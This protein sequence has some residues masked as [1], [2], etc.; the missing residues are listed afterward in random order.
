MVP[1]VVGLSMGEARKQM[2]DL[3]LRVLDDA[4]GQTVTSQMPSAGAKLRKGGQVMLY[5]YTEHMPKPAELVCV[6]DVTGLSMAQAGTLLRQRSLD[7]YME[8]SGLAVKQEPAAGQYAPYNTV[9]HVTFELP[10]P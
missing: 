10:S 7:M 1:N 5:A 6:P 2:A 8:G 9:V 4:A 3:G